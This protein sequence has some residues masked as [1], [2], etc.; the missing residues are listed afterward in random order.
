MEKKT[1]IITILGV[2]NILLT[3][4]GFGVHLIRGLEKR[5][6]FPANVRVMDGGVLGLNLLNVILE[7]DR[8]IAVDVIRSGG[9]P[10]TLYRID[11]D[12]IPTRIKAK[13]SLHQLDFIESLT[14]GAAIGEVPYTVIIGTEPK[15]IETHSLELTPEIKEAIEPVMNMVL[16]ELDNLGIKYKKK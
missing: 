7:S 6:D 1:E 8:L 12:E 4:E 11:N 16:S 5:Y 14:K 9:A 13:N 2:G 3:D 10:G 15:D